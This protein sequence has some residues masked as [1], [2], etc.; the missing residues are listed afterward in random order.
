MTNRD[1][2]DMRYI[3]SL[4]LPLWDGDWPVYDIDVESGLYRIDVCGL[5]EVRSID[6]CITMRDAIGNIH[7]VGDFEIDRSLWEN[8]EE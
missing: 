3:N 4:P 1:R 2:L 7:Y 5:L 8:R 6:R